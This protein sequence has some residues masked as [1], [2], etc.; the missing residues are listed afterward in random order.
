VIGITVS[1]PKLCHDGAGLF[2]EFVASAARQPVASTRSGVEYTLRGID[3]MVRWLPLSLKD[4][5]IA[6]G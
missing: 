2:H 1:S 5:S 6:L 4:F 3:R